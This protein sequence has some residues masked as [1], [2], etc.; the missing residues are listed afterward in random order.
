MWLDDIRN[1]ELFRSGTR[2]HDDIDSVVLQTREFVRFTEETD[3]TDS[4]CVGCAREM[5]PA[6]DTPA[7]SIP[8]PRRVVSDLPE[9]FL[10]ELFGTEPLSVGIVPAE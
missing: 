4:R 5:Y 1:I 7:V 6:T 9:P 8:T 2:S 3:S 10:Q